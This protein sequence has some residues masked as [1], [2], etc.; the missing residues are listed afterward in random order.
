MSEFNGQLKT[1]FLKKSI[2]A[3]FLL[4]SACTSSPSSDSVSDPLKNTKHLVVQGHKSLYENGAFHVPNT[5][6]RLIPPGPS[7]ME[8]AGE[9]MGI[10]ARQSLTT[11]L[12]KAAESFTVVS[13]GTQ[14]TYTLSK[15]FYEGGDKF[16]N[17]VTQ[18]S[19]PGSMLLLKRSAPDA[20]YIMGTSLQSAYH[21][22]TTLSEGGDALSANSL[23]AAHRINQDGSHLSHTLLD[24]SL[25]LG[26]KTVSSGLDRGGE[27][28]DKGLTE[29]IEGYVALPHKLAGRVDAMSVSE[30]WQDYVQDVES[31]GKWR[32]KHSNQMA[33]YVKDATNHYF[34][35][36]KNS[37]DK[38][39]QEL[40][41]AS[42]TGS[43]A[44]LKSLGWALHGVFWQGVM[45]PAGKISAGALGYMALNGVVYPVVMAG[46]GGLSL[47][48]LAVKVSWNTA[49]MAYDIVAP[50]GKAALAGVLA[51]V[52]TGGSAIGGSAIMAAGSAT[53]ILGYSA[54]KVTSATVAVGGYSTGKAIKYIG[55]P[56]ATSGV[57]LTGAAVS[58]AVATT[59]VI[60]G[61]VLGAGGELVSGS[62]KI[63]A[64][65]LAGTTLVVGTSASVVTGASYGVYQLSKAVVVPSTYTL[66]SGV[67]L[68][69]GSLS[70]IAGHSILA[71][72]DASYMVLSM[73]GPNWVLYSVKGMLGM[74]EELAP[75]TVLDLENMQKEGEQFKK[76]PITPAEMDRVIKALPEDLT[77]QSI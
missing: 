48:E 65:G 49:G 34:S 69:Y 55:V 57:A 43:F 18:H 45:K 76:L 25:E 67:V 32:E 26:A 33:F 38:S 72:S 27:T 46:K 75:G 12:N 8:F 4:L 50:T 28:L 29:F 56:I 36:V 15:A 40:D 19:R 7:A 59:E 60:A 30:T 68:G 9:L 21:L 70:Q 2:L 77:V 35:G 66:S 37:F 44:I 16:S 13:V 20:K 58:V 73:E 54:T 64:T 41:W 61:S 62:S 52:Q 10:N 74:G 1:A 63:A 47:A 39:Q 6:I 14:K 31:T 22:G 51:T 71:V 3:M 24:K 11:S 5:S 42:Q 53:S 23:G 17:W